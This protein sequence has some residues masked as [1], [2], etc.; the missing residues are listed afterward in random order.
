MIHTWSWDELLWSAVMSCGQLVLFSCTSRMVL[1]WDITSPN[2]NSQNWK[3]YISLDRE[4]KTNFIFI[5]CWN[6][7][8]F[9]NP[10][11]CRLV[12]SNQIWTIVA[13]NGKITW[14]QNAWFMWKTLK[15]K[16]YWSGKSNIIKYNIPSFNYSL[17]SIYSSAKIWKLCY[18]F[19]MLTP[20]PRRS[21]SST[22]KSTQYFNEKI[23]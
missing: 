19:P 15:R 16:N 8:Y 13:T 22:Q 12:K 2:Y 14:T 18:D 11:F 7:A 21:S 5:I 23:F 4:S 17:I 6:L 3:N 1:T 10:E 20:K 9:L